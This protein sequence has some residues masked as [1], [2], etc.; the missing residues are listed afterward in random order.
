MQKKIF[1]LSFM[2]VGTLAD[3]VLPFLW[4]MIA[5]IPILMFCWW[6]AYRSGWFIE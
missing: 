5:T 1:W 3:I 4:G 6:L 2:V